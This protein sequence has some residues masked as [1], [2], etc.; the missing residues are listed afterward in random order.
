MRKTRGVTRDQGSP[1]DVVIQKQ[2]KEI[3]GHPMMIECVSEGSEGEVEEKIN[4]CMNGFQKLPGVERKQLE[5]IEVAVRRSV[6]ASGKRRGTERE[7]TAE[8]EQCNKVRFA[9]K[10][11][12][13]TAR[14]ETQAQSTDKQGVMSGLEE[15]SAGRGSAGLVRGEMTGVGRTDQRKRERKWE[16]RKRRTRRKGRQWRQRISGERE[17]VE[18]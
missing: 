8:M 14:G 4:N 12:R 3:E 5:N 1:E 18:G 17:C 15:V 7:Q 16:R 11:P 2:K 9:E 10:E 6:E 13:R